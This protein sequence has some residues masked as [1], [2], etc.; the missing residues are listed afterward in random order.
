M[1]LALDI[2]VEDLQGSLWVA[3]LHKH[4]IEALEIDPYAELVRWGSI[5][6]A[7]IDRIDAGLN[8]AFLDL[9]HGVRGMLPAAEIP[10]MKKDGKIGRK[11]RSGQFVM[12]QVKTAHQPDIDPDTEDNKRAT[13]A[14]YAV[15]PGLALPFARRDIGID[16]GAAEFFEGDNGGNSAG[17]HFAL[18]RDHTDTAPDLVT[19]SA[20]QLHE[21]TL[22][23]RVFCFADHAPAD[24]DCRIGSKNERVGM[25]RGNFT[26]LRLGQTQYHRA[27]RFIF[28]R[29]FINVGGMDFRDNPELRQKLQAVGRGRSED[30]CAVTFHGK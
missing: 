22:L 7:R 10:G 13:F 29:C 5:Y 2:V 1:T 14:L 12:V 8:A 23:V 28:Q 6:W 30:K 15:T 3:A 27:R 20:K 17:D 16:L 26:C 18:R 24:R 4:K 21:F 9:G 19:A 25:G 11:L